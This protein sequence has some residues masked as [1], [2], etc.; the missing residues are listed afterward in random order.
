MILGALCLVLIGW[1]LT[2]GVD[3]GNFWVKIGCTVVVTAIYAMAWQ[4]PR[5]RVSWASIGLGVASA[6]VLYAIFWI[7]NAVSAWIIPN[8]AADVG[9]IYDLGGDGDSGVLA[10][11][12]LLLLLVTGPGEE[13]FW[14][15]FLQENLARRFGGVTGFLLATLL[16]GSIH[17]FSMNVMLTGAAFVAGGFWG[18]LYLWRRDTVT[19]IVSHSLWSA[20]IFAIVPIR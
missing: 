19:L 5:L 20:T 9:R 2:F 17:V 18:A 4:R 11:I 12:F 15:G 16:Y 8:A 13:I 3:V 14:R 10:R 1:G 6:I 7:G